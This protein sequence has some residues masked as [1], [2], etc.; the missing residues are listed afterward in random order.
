MNYRRDP[1]VR[2]EAEV[3]FDSGHRVRFLACRQFGEPDRE[4]IRGV[5]VVKL[6]GLSHARARASTLGYCFTA[7]TTKLIEY[8]FMGIPRAIRIFFGPWRREGARTL[9]W[10][11]VFTP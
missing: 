11:K 8:E 2:R 5:E 1:R 6:P 3:S 9:R 4:V 10:A 7:S